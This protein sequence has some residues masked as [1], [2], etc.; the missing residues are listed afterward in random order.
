MI[1]IQNLNLILKNFKLKD[2]SLQISEG[3]YMVLLG[4]NGCGKTTLARAICGLLRVDSGKIILNGRDVTNLEP[5][6]RNIGFVPQDSGLFPNLTVEEN[7]LFTLVVK[8][9]KKRFAL[10]SAQNIIASFGLEKILKRYPYNL[11]GG[12]KQKTALARALVGKPEILI[13][14]EPLSTL[15]PMAHTEISD[16]LSHI[17]E[18]FKMTTLHICHN[19]HEASKLADRAAIMS[20]GC[21]EAVG[22]LDEIKPKLCNNI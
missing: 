15:D 11:S 22:K 17:N 3:E 14:D 12:E 10:D 20:N 18:S 13:L 5:R 1:V 4:P 21:L 16:I 7:V 9:M 8:G 19:L 2:I 6:F